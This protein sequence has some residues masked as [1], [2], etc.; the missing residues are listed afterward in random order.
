MKKIFFVL[1]ILASVAFVAPR[2]T[3]AGG[4]IA[5]SVDNDYQALMWSTTNGRT[6]ITG[7][8]VDRNALGGAATVVV[9]SP[10]LGGQTVDQ[11]KTTISRPDV[12]RAYGTTYNA[13]G[14]NWVVPAR[15]YTGGTYDFDFYVMDGAGGEY[16][17]GS[18]RVSLTDRGLRGGVDMV[19]GRTITGW[20]ADLDGDDPRNQ[21]TSV[22]VTIDGQQVGMALT[23][24]P[25]SDVVNYWANGDYRAISATSGFNF[26]IDIPQRFRDGKGHTVHVFALEFTEGTIAQIG[27][28]QYKTITTE[29]LMQ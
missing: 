10:S 2:I 21:K 11:F 9:K 24:Q 22:L 29:G 4:S 12:A 7:W 25:R 13:E 14:F 23:D 26:V 5:G 18:R 17:I 28:T 1:A 15:F 6:I 8:A 3:H 16:K 20:A 27:A 19:S